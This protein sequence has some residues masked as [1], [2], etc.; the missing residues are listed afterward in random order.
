MCLLKGK[1]G[2]F[3]E[4]QTEVLVDENTEIVVTFKGRY[5][6]GLPQTRNEPEEKPFIDIEKVEVQEGY[7]AFIKDI[8]F[9][10]E[11]DDDFKDEIVDLLWQDL[12][13]LRERMSRRSIN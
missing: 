6:P 4:A 12:E 11:N 5:Y 3:V 8:W 10:L 1:R 7:D 9:R 13:Y 2:C